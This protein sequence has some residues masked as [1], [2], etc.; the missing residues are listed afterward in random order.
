MS[1]NKVIMWYISIK[2]TPLSNCTLLLVISSLDCRIMRPG[3]IQKHANGHLVGL[4]DDKSHDLIIKCNDLSSV[5]YGLLLSVTSKSN[6]TNWLREKH[7][8]NT[9]Q[10]Q[11]FSFYWTQNTK[12]LFDFDIACLNKHISNPAAY[13]YARSTCYKWPTTTRTVQPVPRKKIVFLQWDMVTDI[14]LHYRCKTT[15][16]SKLI[17]N[18]RFHEKNH[19]LK[20]RL[21]LMQ[22]NETRNRNKNWLSNNHLTSASSINLN[23]SVSV[24]LS[25]L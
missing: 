12:K 6:L 4:W 8:H 11:S 7:L 17:F 13:L 1:L 20:E 21:T 9:K 16:Y 19:L 18:A 10:W 23:D 24:T 2:L 5:F 15:V 22:I 14:F 3:Y 25:L